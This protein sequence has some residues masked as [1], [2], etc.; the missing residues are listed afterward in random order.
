MPVRAVAELRRLG[1]QP[2]EIAR[3][4]PHLTLTQVYDALSD[5][6]DHRDEINGDIERNR[7]AEEKIDPLVRDAEATSS[8][9]SIWTRTRT[10]T[11]PSPRWPV[12]LRT[13][14]PTAP[15]AR[16]PARP[17]AAPEPLPLHAYGRTVSGRHLVVFSVLER[18]GWVLPISARD[19]SGL[20]RKHYEQA[21]EG[22]SPV[23]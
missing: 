5:C 12:I 9:S 1:L 13:C 20:E 21:K 18:P 19:M 23:G 22:R 17:A 6:S 14:P 10:R 16:A 8:S 7:I 2:N 15:P 4:L 11:S 3:R